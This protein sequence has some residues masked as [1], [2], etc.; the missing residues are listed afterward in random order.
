MGVLC[1]DLF[2]WRRHVYINDLK[3]CGEG[4]IEVRGRPVSLS[5]GTRS[6]YV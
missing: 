5:V 4:N 1:L 3:I 6:L 2:S